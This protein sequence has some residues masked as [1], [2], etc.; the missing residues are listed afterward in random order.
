MS[1]NDLSTANIDAPKPGPEP[2]LQPSTSRPNNAERA[3]SSTSS[4]AAVPVAEREND[5]GSSTGKEASGLKWYKKHNSKKANG[6]QMSVGGHPYVCRSMSFG[7][8]YDEQARRF[9]DVQFWPFVGPL[10]PPGTSERLPKWSGLRNMVAVATKGKIVVARCTA[11]NPWDILMVFHIE[12]H[13][14]SLS[15]TYDPITFRPLIVTG[16]QKSLLYVVDIL[17]RTFVRV[18]RGHGGPILCITTNLLYPHIIAST[19]YDKTVRI[20][21]IRGADAPSFPPDER[22]EENYPMADADEGTCVVAILVGEGHGGHRFYVTSVAFHPTKNAIA[23]CGVD[24]A[25]KIWPLPPLPEPEV[26]ISP[27]PIGYRPTIVY[28]PLF[29][30]TRMFADFTDYIEWLS[31]DT[32]ITRGRRELATW[33]WIGYKRYFGP[34]SPAP[35]THEP[36]FSD[37]TD[38]GSYMVLARYDVGSDLWAIG[39]GYHREFKPRT[40]KEKDKINANPDL[41]T[42]PLIALAVHPSGKPCTSPEISLFNPLLADETAGRPPKPPRNP[43]AG[44]TTSNPN[45]SLGDDGADPFEGDQNSDTATA[46]LKKA[47]PAAAAR[48]ILN[49]TGSLTEPIVIDDSDN[50]SNTTNSKVPPSNNGSNVNITTP[51]EPATNLDADIVVYPESSDSD[52]EDT[53]KGEER[54]PTLEPWRLIAGNWQQVT[55]QF[56]KSKILPDNR[57]PRSGFAN[58]CNVAISPRGAEFIVG[59]GEH[60]TVFVWSLTGAKGDV[61]ED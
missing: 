22:P 41:V 16:G 4:F 42:D 57:K 10:E 7:N 3:G 58:L 28:L 20:W 50:E 11:K 18:L 39:P 40:A 52:D 27:T 45:D 15:W 60:E 36:V 23:S 55:K 33:Q 43:R 14:Y 56:A 30:T 5:T 53:P 8:P 38:S 6:K 32:L 54:N 12:D 19:S 13:L 61:N 37:F 44:T 46:E 34:G 49:R 48:P 9:E 1:V 17:D 35:F 26:S 31:E 21:N 51:T 47:A 24:R 59:V 29:S 2:D 25:V